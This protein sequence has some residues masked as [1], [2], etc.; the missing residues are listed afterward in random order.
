MRPLPHLAT[1]SLRAHLGPL[2]ARRQC[3]PVHR[4]VGQHVAVK[5]KRDADLAVPQNAGSPISGWAPLESKCVA[6]ACPQAVRLADKSSNRQSRTFWRPSTRKNSLASWRDSDR[7]AAS[8]WLLGSKRLRNP[9]P[10]Y[11][12]R[13]P[14]HHEIDP[15]A[16]PDRYVGFHRLRGQ[17]SNR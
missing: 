9:H 10:R 17:A 3:W 11:R 8:I 15:L 4:S 12:S 2:S 7:G 16:R 14:S 6:W 13:C 1:L 5:I